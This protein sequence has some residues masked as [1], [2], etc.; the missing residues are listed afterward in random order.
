MHRLALTAY[1]AELRDALAL[2]VAL[3]RTLVLPRRVCYCDKLWAG[4]D[5]ILNTKCMYPGS[6]DHSFL[7]FACPMDHW[8]SPH[9]W[10]GTVRYRDAVAIEELIAR[11]SDGTAVRDVRVMPHEAWKALRWAE[12]R[13]A[14]DALPAG[15]WTADRVVRHLV[16][17]GGGDARVLRL[18]HTRSLLCGIGVSQGKVREA[19]QRA[20]KLLHAPPWCTRCRDCDE[21]LK[22]WSVPPGAGRQRGQEWCLQI[23][24]PPKFAHGKCVLSV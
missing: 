7:P 18:E 24:P 2:A 21:R 20:Q 12:G 6:Q 23:T 16:G 17:G 8:L 14:S 13:A 22:R 11:D 3:G 9:S 5:D 1:L 4:S 19:N 15:V 10:E